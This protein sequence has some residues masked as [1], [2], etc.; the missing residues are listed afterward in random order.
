VKKEIPTGKANSGSAKVDDPV[1]R[2]AFTP[3]TVKSAYL[4]SPSSSKLAM[5]P[6]AIACLRRAPSLA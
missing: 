4:N 1:G 5:T 2:M 3:A 6:I